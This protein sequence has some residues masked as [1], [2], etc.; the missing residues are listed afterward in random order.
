MC[1]V[2]QEYILAPSDRRDVHGIAVL[3]CSVSLRN[4]YSSPSKPHFK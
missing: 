2:N 1:P 4:A 3:V